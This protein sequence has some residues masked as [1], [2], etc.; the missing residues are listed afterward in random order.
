MT[1]LLQLSIRSSRAK[2]GSNESEMGSEGEQYFLVED[3][4]H[5]SQDPAEQTG[6]ECQG[7]RQKECL[8]RDVALFKLHGE[9]RFGRLF[10]VP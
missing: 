5:F 10:I 8:S 3:V 9:A 2:K 4:A 1:V 7:S 6:K